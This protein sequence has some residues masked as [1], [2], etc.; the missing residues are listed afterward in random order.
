MRFVYINVW[1]CPKADY[2][3]GLQRGS[4]FFHLPLPAATPFF[5]TDNYS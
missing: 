2:D 5:A 3:V 1:G 4:L